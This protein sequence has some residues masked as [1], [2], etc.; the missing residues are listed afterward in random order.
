MSHP[1]KHGEQDN[2][3]P[4]N[5]AGTEAEAETGTA[6][7]AADNAADDAA[8]AGQENDP[9]AE[10]A[11]LRDRL[12]RTIAEMENLRRRTEREKADAARFGIARFARDILGVADNL[13]RALSAAPEGEGAARD[14]VE[15]VKLTERELHAIFE[16]H[17]IRKVMPARGEKFDPNLHQAMAEV[18]T[19]E[20]PPGTV[21]DVMQAG[22]ALDERLLR[23]AMVTVARA[24][25]QAA[26]SDGAESDTRPGSSIDTSV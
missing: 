18:P 21:V 25:P 17:N 14:F 7:A 16:R 3:A 4:E 19:N 15:G 12:L 24:A 13:A 26:D 6:E 22:Y 9:A 8:D 2:G 11:E 10:A 23:A 20:V 1:E 5:G